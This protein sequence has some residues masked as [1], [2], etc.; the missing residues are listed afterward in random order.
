MRL[1]AVWFSA[2]QTFP[3]Y[4]VGK[5]DITE[6]VMLADGHGPTGK[7]DV[8]Y[9]YKGESRTRWAAMP[10]HMAHFWEYE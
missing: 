4:Q 9:F 7:Y 3:A 10:A 5:G 1:K 6:I 2:D 8:I